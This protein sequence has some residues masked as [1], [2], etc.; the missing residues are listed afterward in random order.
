MKSLYGSNINHVRLTV[1]DTKFRIIIADIIISREYFSAEY[2]KQ[3]LKTS[4]YGLEV[5]TITT[6][7]YR[8]YPEIIE[9]LRAKK[10]RCSFHVMKNLMD[11]IY[12]IHPSLKRK[13]KKAEKKNT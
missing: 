3:F 6:D 1:I 4:L 7:G 5:D 2:I 8:A 13:I 11:D 10:Q 9:S 12:P